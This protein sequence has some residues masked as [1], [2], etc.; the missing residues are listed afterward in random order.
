M[1]RIRIGYPDKPV[2]KEILQIEPARSRLGSLEPVI[3][4]EEILELQD[5][6]DK[7]KVD[8]GILEYILDISEATRRSDE[9]TVGLSPRA[10]LALSAAARASA[11]LS[12]RDY[13]VP[14]DVRDI[15]VAV[16]AHRLRTRSFVNDETT[17][18]SEEIFRKILETVPV[19]Q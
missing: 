3:S 8:E 17:H 12:G 7:V 9:L 4:V 10:S 6:V 19:P 16:G 1:L 13:V 11:L 14:D 18:A 15:A 2:E 5:K